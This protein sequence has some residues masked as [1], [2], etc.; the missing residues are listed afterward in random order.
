MK[1]EHTILYVTEEQRASEDEIHPRKLQKAKL[2]AKR[3]P[4]F[5]DLMKAEQHEAIMHIYNNLL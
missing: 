3:S 2:I 4:L 1:Q 5:D